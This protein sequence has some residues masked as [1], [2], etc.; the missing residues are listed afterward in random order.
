MTS[1]LRKDYFLDRFVII[2][3]ERGKRPDEYQT[4][5]V[6][7]KKPKFCPFCKKRNITDEEVDRTEFNGKWVIRSLKN[8]YPIT[9]NKKGAPKKSFFYSMPNTGCHEVVI[10]TPEHKKQM[11]D[12]SIGEM[13]LYL[14]FIRKRT[15]KIFLEKDTAYVYAFKNSGVNAGASLD[16]SHSQIVSMRIIPPLIKTEVKKAED[17]LKEKGRCPFLD[18]IK[19]EKKK[20]EREIADFKTIYV[21][22]PFA[23]RYEF[24]AQILIKRCR[25]SILNLT[26][27]EI[28]D[29]A[30][31]LVLATRKLKNYD[32]NLFFHQSFNNEN[33]HFHIEVCP[34][35]TDEA[36]M[37]EGISLSVTEIYPEDAAK[38]YR[39]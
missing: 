32:Y 26:N 39:K 10:E 37:E 12:F 31:A 25:S 16:H 4:K 35:L 11:S 3:T 24:E 1:E 33:Y 15:E 8:I 5:R 22:S 19:N 21:F 18:I 17:Y 14:E 6:S 38:F 23:S 2:S 34:R 7:I 13:K 36:G 28:D 9:T 27:E 20:K 30:K 29:L